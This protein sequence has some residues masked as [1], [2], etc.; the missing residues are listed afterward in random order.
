MHSVKTSEKIT[1]SRAAT[2]VMAFIALSLAGGL[3]LATAILPVAAS[4]GTASNATMKL[5]DDLPTSIDF[6]HPSEK[7]SILAADGTLLATFYAEN[8]I[9]VASDQ[10]SD[11]LKHAAVAIEDERFFEHAGIDA[12]GII[13]AAFNNLTGGRLAGGSTITQQY[14][15]NS[16]IEEGRFAEDENQINAATETSVS[17]KL[18]EARYALA[19]EKQM[20][21]DEI[22]TSYL[23]IA[24]F[25]PSQWGVEAASRFFFSKSAKDVTIPEAAMIAGN[26]QAPNRWNP[27][28]NPE[29]TQKRR[30]VVLGKMH[31]L[32][33]ITKEEYDAAVKVNI[34]D[35]LHVSPAKNGCEM[36]GNAAY[37][38]ETVITDILNS[39]SWGKSRADRVKQLYRGG[40]TIT[41]T[42]DLKTQNAAYEALISEV[43]IADPSNVD[44]ASVSVEPNTGK[45]LAMVQNTNFGKPTEKDPD[46]TQVNANVGKLRG[47]GG[48]YQAGSTFKI[49]TLGEWLRSGRSPNDLVNNNP[50]DFTG[51]DFPV[52]CAPDMRFVGKY[53]PQNSGGVTPGTQTVTT[54]TINSYNVG[55]LEMA[56]KVGICNVVKLATDMGAEQGNITDKKSVEKYKSLNAKLG[57]PL[58]I[59]PNPATIIGTTTVTPISM[60]TAAASF[61]ADGKKCTPITYTEIRARD[62]KSL[63]KQEPNCE[64]ILPENVARLANQVL[65]QVPRQEARNGLISG[66]PSAGKT[67]T[68]NE[69]ADAWYIGYTPGLASA[70][71]LGHMNGIKPM[72]NIN[73]NGRFYRE[74]Y[75]L[76][77][78]AKIFGKFASQALAGKEVRQFNSP[79]G[80][81]SLQ[82]QTEE[83]KQREEELKREQERENQEHAGQKVP[84]V[85]GMEMN[86]AARALRAQGYVVAPAGVWSNQP[87]NTVVSTT[88][89]AGSPIAPGSTIT[90]NISA[91]PAPQH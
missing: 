6:T 45:V 57:K 2:A 25:G 50:R 41:T 84:N 43:P 42:L 26:T 73:I 49:F 12:K 86:A 56:S 8:R 3:A 30:D 9:V 11:H 58:P 67:G 53:R 66:H 33:Y 20:T 90:L 72:L 68:T 13:G 52:P 65:Q 19:I 61:A 14:V 37:F 80:R 60:A 34:A 21:K 16:L 38:C 5:F 79:R 7:S 69:A 48:G 55:Y 81:I 36:A 18:N 64:Q 47:G 78:P 87:K 44:A 82:M 28:E 39:D 35:M 54:T 85:A 51:K 40:L 76:G 22:L 74:V 89:A 24:Q 31:Q 63:A 62:G 32:G 15:K 88:P 17:R 46:A 83:E 4:V 70:V 71:W 75:G 10:I 77:I 1:A 59:L 29:E 23:N 27:L 91:G